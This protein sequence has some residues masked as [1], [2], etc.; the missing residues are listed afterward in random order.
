M[1]SFD[2]RHMPADNTNPKKTNTIT[3]KLLLGALLSKGI[4]TGLIVVNTGVS[5][6][7]EA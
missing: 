5:L 7:P 4:V 2:Q 1:G 3:I 6:L